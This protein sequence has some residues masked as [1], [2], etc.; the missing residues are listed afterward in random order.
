V[1]LDLKLNGSGQVRA[2]F[3]SFAKP[4]AGKRSFRANRYAGTAA[5]GAVEWTWPSDHAK[6]FL[7]YPRCRDDPK[8]ANRV[9]GM[10]MVYRLV[11]TRV[12]ATFVWFHR[13]DGSPLSVVE[14][15]RTLPGRVSPTLRI[16]A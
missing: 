11:I 3:A 12:P 8:T 4:D 15:L 2:F 16:D 1:T 14:S 10:R 5:G 6:D 7:G 9:I 13:V